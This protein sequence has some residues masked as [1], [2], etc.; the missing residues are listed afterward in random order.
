MSGR[1][2]RR[3]KRSHKV[4]GAYGNRIQAPDVGDKCSHLVRRVAALDR[5]ERLFAT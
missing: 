1:Q 2:P 4:I 5:V 3:L